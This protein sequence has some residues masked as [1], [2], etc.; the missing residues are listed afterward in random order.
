MIRNQNTQWFRAAASLSAYAR[1]CLTGTPIQNDLED[2]AALVQFIRVPGLLSK[3]FKAYC[4]TSVEKKGHQGFDNIRKLLQCICI[5]RTQDLLKLPEFNQVE[6][7]LELSPNEFTAYND[8]CSRYRKAIDDEICGRKPSDAYRSI[9]QALLKL[10]LVCN[11]GAIPEV[12]TL[13]SHHEEEVLALL[14]EGHMLCA[15]CESQIS[16]DGAD[17]DR[18]AAKLEPCGHFLCKSCV[19]KYPNEEKVRDG[20]KSACPGCS[21]SL[22]E[23]CFVALR[24]SDN[25]ESEPSPE[26]RVI[27]TKFEEI[28]KDIKTQDLSEKW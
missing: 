1:W 22:H 25:C 12:S 13:S 16:L 20:F 8:V 14:Q 11:H 26:K 7:Q 6:R 23:K 2:L 17:T 21:T 27:S 28:I 3:D 4:T 19:E 10:R 15:V 18:P 9:F 24:L 5:R